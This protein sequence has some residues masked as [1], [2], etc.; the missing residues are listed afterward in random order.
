MAYQKTQIF[1]KTFLEKT[2]MR[3]TISSLF[4]IFFVFLLMPMVLAERYE[5]NL[6][7][8]IEIT[9]QG[10]LVNEQSIDDVN[11]IGFVCSSSNCATVSNTLW[12]SAILNSG[13]DTPSDFLQLVYPTTLQ[14]SYG[15]CLVDSISYSQLSLAGISRF[16]SAG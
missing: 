16:R 14:S 8:S 3:K 4:I 6:F 12:N 2:N 13:T 10:D 1:K 9:N 7:K 15:L 11:V 5:D